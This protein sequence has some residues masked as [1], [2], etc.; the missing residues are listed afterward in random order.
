MVKCDYCGLATSLVTGLHLYPCRTDLKDKLFWKCFDCEAWVG[1]HPG[2]KKPLGR[3]ANQELR[4]WKMLAHE[5]FDPR[6][7]YPG[8]KTSRSRRRGKAYHW[9][10]HQMGLE[11]ANCHIGMFD[12][13]Q[14]KQVIAICRR[15]EKS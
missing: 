4:K 8:A 2:T 5:A 1:C 7:N 6:W 13:D 9:L 12:V 3:L 10:R 11:K 14:C 15:K